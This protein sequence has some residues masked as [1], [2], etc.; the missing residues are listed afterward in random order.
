[1]IITTGVLVKA[2]RDNPGASLARLY[3]EKMLAA[4]AARDKGDMIRYNKLYN[5]AKE[6]LLM[7]RRLNKSDSE[8]QETHHYHR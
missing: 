8:N 1:M 5:D 4:N 6:L 3:D 2:L 7:I